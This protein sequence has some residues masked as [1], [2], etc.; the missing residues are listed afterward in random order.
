MAT[1]STIS[2]VDVKTS[3][4]KGRQIYSH[5]DGYPS[6]VGKTLL[7]HYQDADKVKQLI[8][9]G[10]ISSLREEIEILEGVKHDFDSP[11]ENITIAYG[12]DRGEEDQQAKEFK[13]GKPDE[14]YSEEFDY[15]FVESK[16]QWFV[17][18][19]HVLNARFVRLTQK[20]VDRD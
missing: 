10:N 4:G 8:D 19:N 14:K 9:L 16:N 1:R 15:L 17:R 6:G 18:N 5:W 12:R 7:E 11:Q 3:K 20:M 2:I 13:G